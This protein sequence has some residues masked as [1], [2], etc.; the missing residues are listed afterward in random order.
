MAEA[1]A[2]AGI[3]ND[4]CTRIYVLHGWE[5]VVV[6]LIERY[7]YVLSNVGEDHIVG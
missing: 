7:V 3:V 6:H 5:V 1:K 2:G 4:P